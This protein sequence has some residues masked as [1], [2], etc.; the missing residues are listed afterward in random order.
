LVSS[1]NVIPTLA[2]A[3]TTASFISTPLFILLGMLCFSRCIS[4]GP[5]CSVTVPIAALVAA[6]NRN[7]VIRTSALNIDCAISC[8]TLSHRHV[9]AR[10]SYF[11]F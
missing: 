10:T 1:S 7:T 4:V 11:N 3:V 9:V 8:A 5:V 6:G 2:L